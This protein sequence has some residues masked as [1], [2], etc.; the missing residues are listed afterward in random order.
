MSDNSNNGLQRVPGVP[1][2]NLEPI[3]PLK[4]SLSFF[5]ITFYGLET[6]LGAGIYGVVKHA[7][8]PK[9]F[10]S[11]HPVTQ[12]SI[13]VTMS[14]ALLILVLALVFSIEPLA[15]ITGTI[16]P[17][18]FF[19]ITDAILPSLFLLLLIGV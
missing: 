9:R 7:D 12:I 19:S 16:I 14:F 15:Q 2:S 13:M 8:A 17:F 6:M 1:M 11:V 3:T 10:T 4:R 5:L 18:S